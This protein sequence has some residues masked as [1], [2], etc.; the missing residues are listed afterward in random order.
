MPTVCIDAKHSSYF[1]L[2]CQQEA[3]RTSPTP[4]LLIKSAQDA[5]SGGPTAATPGRGS[6]NPGIQQPL[7]VSSR[8]DAG[9]KL[10]AALVE[11]QTVKAGLSLERTPLADAPWPSNLGGLVSARIVGDRDELTG[12]GTA[13][14]QDRLRSYT[15]HMTPCGMS[16]ECCHATYKPHICKT[17]LHT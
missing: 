12:L 13:I 4:L 5:V 2:Q 3:R 8:S 7:T 6:P 10:K 9:A 17:S 15:T 1:A 16:L 14:N 11:R